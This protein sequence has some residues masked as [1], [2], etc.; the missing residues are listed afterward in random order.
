MMALSN[1]ALSVCVPALNEEETLR[2]AVEDLLT[3][4][5]PE[6]G[7][8]EVII[9][10]DGSS[11]DTGKIGEALALRHGSGQV[12][13]HTLRPGSGQA[14][15]PSSGQA[16]VR[17]LHHAQNMG[18]GATYRDALAVATGDFFT[19][20]PADH[21]NQA[22][23]LVQ[24][25]PHLAPGVIVTT[26]HVDTD[27]RPLYRRVPSRFYTKTLNRLFGLRVR[28]YNGLTIYPTADLRS[29]ALGAQG[30][31]MQAEAMV[32]VGRRGLRIV[33]LEHPLGKRTSGKSALVSWRALRQ[34][35]RDCVR[36]WR[37]GR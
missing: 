19:W 17:V 7:R 11:D 36:I 13:E 23:E 8:L 37:A 32:K 30:F 25:I 15:R 31:A 1:I 6:V 5:G 12:A 18:F 20:F 24:S 29:V 10:N 9:V 16:W 35:L 21:E 26:Q 28:Y 14:L 2:A 27:P 4:L 22:T 34:A 3:S 33:E